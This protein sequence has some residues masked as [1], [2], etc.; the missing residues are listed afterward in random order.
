MAE[1]SF[2]DVEV[3]ESLYWWDNSN[4]ELNNTVVSSVFKMGDL[5]VI[6][7][8]NIIV[9]NICIPNRD[10]NKSNIIIND[11]SD[12]NLHVFTTKNEAKIHLINSINARIA[13][14]ETKKIYL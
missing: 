14:L 10:W 6:A 11:N 9:N 1:N 7:V 2:N 3:G 8:E 12:I 13:F 4:F 5:L